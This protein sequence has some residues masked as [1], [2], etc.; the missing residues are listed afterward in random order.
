MLCIGGA[1][2]SKRDGFIVSQGEQRR[3]Q[4]GIRGGLGQFHHAAYERGQAIAEVVVAVDAGDFFNEVDFALNVQTPGGQL[5]RE[6]VGRLLADGETQ[7]AEDAENIFDRDLLPQDARHLAAAQPDRT[8]QHLARYRVDL[9]AGK[10][11]ATGSQNQFGH[12]RAGQ[13]SRA[14]VGATFKA[15]RGIGMHALTACRLANTCRV[16]PSGFDKNVFRLFRDHGVKAAHDSRQGHRLF[17]VSDDQV[18]RMQLALDAVECLE[19]FSGTGAAHDD[20]P[21]LQQVKIEGVRGMA[22]LPQGIVGRIR[23]VVDGALVH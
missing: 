19:H 6:L 15:V 12:T 23:D 16:E 10:L 3:A 17:G 8:P 9:T 2:E 14:K 11:A 20:S 18:F 22:H 7:A 5:Y 1:D 13:G 4:L 21:A